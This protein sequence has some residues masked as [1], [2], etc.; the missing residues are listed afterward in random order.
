MSR[1][2][3]GVALTGHWLP[4]D[5][6]Q[7]LCARADALGYEVVLVDGD[8]AQLPRRPEAPIYDS[9]ALAGSVV[10]DAQ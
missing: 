4:L 8:T 6:V 1:P 10:E 7:R 2:R 5:S 3:R 9:S